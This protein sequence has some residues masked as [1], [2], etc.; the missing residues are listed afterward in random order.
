MT[1]AMLALNEAYLDA[2]GTLDAELRPALRA[3]CE[4]YLTARLRSG[5]DPETDCPAT[6]ALAA[7]LLML[8][9]YGSL[10]AGGAAASFTA[11]D[12]TIAGGAAGD[13]ADLRGRALALLQPWL[14]D[15]PFACRSVRV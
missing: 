12:L 10:Q 6:F 14:A 8:A 7:A 4:A 2:D 15:G 3:A 11:G 5:A 1:E 9:E 13:S